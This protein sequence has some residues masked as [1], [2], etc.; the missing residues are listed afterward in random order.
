VLNDGATP[1]YR[2]SRSAELA[3]LS[4]NTK[5]RDTARPTFAAIRPVEVG[6]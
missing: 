2:D 3:F 1:N 5:P 4:K 6:K